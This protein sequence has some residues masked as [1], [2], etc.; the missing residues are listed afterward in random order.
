MSTTDDQG[1][2]HI[3]PADVAAVAKEQSLLPTRDD[4]RRMPGYWEKPAKVHRTGVGLVDGYKWGV[5]ASAAKGEEKLRA[6]HAAVGELMA[7]SWNAATERQLNASGVEPHSP[8]RIKA[9]RRYM[10]GQWYRRVGCHWIPER[11]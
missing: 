3:G 7:P 4:F 1:N 9:T 11:G 5:S 8:M 10:D 6:H 2:V